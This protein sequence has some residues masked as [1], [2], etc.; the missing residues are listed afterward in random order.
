MGGRNAAQGSDL[1]PDVKENGGGSAADAFGG[2]FGDGF[3]L[4][5]GINFANDFNPDESIAETWGRAQQAHQK[6][7][8]GFAQVDS[9]EINECE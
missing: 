1:F 6:V 3:G 2:G 8:A 4:L 7:C 9:A 5:D